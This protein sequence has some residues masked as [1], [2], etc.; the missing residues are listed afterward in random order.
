MAYGTGDHATAVQMLK[1][2]Y[3]TY[4]VEKITVGTKEY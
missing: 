1:E 4:D 2:T 3:P